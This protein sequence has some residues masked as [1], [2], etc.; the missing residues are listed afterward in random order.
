MLNN[1]LFTQVLS[2]E[3][4]V[5]QAHNKCSKC[6]PC[7]VHACPQSLS[8]WLTAESM[9]VCCRS[10]HFAV[11]WIQIWTVWRPEVKTDE[12]RCLPLQ[13]LDGVAGAICRSAVTTSFDTLELEI[14]MNYS[15]YSQL[16]NASFAWDVTNRL[17]HFDW[18]HGFWH[19][20]CSRWHLCCIGCRSIVPVV[21]IFFN[22]VSILPHFEQLLRACL[23]DTSTERTYM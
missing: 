3:V 21:R 1:I 6:H 11:D 5:R 9:T 15:V 8:H 14:T 23:T 16:V 12:V 20:Q 7:A 18:P 22:R 10:S 19:F 17:V 2:V 13:Q 4:T